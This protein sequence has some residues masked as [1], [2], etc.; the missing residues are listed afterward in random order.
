MSTICIRGIPSSIRSNFM[1]ARIVWQFPDGVSSKILKD[2]RLGQRVL[3]TL[4]AAP[5][6]TQSSNDTRASLYLNLFWCGSRGVPEELQIPIGFDSLDCESVTAGRI[7]SRLRSLLRAQGGP[8]V[9]S[10]VTP[11]GPLE[12]MRFILGLLQG[13]STESFQSSQTRRYLSEP[14]PLPSTSCECPLILRIPIK[15]IGCGSR[16]AAGSRL[17]H[18]RNTMAQDSSRGVPGV[19]VGPWTIQSPCS[20]VATPG[21]SLQLHTCTNQRVDVPANAPS[22]PAAVPLVYNNGR[23]SQEF[24]FVTLLFA[25]EEQREEFNGCLEEI[26]CA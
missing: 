5:L 11:Q 23:A 17:R 9:G 25:S 21:H 8:D 1:T 19:R 4:T 18:I 13:D 26:L 14:A 6:H 10:A 20:D 15:A 3:M 22:A 2:F 16:S 7:P 24:A 12:V